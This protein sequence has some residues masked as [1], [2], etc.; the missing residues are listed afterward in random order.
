MPFHGVVVATAAGTLPRE[1]A[2]GI[3]YKKF[4]VSLDGIWKLSRSLFEC[5]KCCDCHTLGLAVLLTSWRMCVAAVH[6]I[7]PIAVHAPEVEGKAVAF[8]G[9]GEALALSLRIEGI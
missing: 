6:D 1:L 4:N 8:A 9:H 5:S 2:Y 7:D 3:A